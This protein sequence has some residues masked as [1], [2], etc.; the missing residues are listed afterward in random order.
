[1][2]SEFICCSG[3]IMNIISVIELAGNNLNGHILA[4]PNAL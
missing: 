3:C 2:I 1:M 4:R